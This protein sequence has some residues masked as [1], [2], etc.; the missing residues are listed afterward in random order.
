MPHA[1]PV[2][3][4]TKSLVHIATVA[5]FQCFIPS[6]HFK[7]E[8]CISS[9]M[10]GVASRHPFAA[11]ATAILLVLVVIVSRTMVVSPLLSSPSMTS[12]CRSHML[13]RASMRLSL[14]SLPCSQ[15]IT[16]IVTTRARMTLPC[17]SH[18]TPLPTLPSPLLAMASAFHTAGHAVVRSCG[19]SSCGTVASSAL[20]LTKSNLAVWC[21]FV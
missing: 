11:A 12:P 3:P 18:S 21:R 9:L 8:H 1:S 13:R 7:V 19:L 5:S 16:C 15:G 20:Q 4:A 17:P 6:I 2:S 10:F 14:H